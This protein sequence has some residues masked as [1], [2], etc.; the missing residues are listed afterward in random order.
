MVRVM[1]LPKNRE[2]GHWSKVPIGTLL[3]LLEG[4]VDELRKAITGRA[5]LAE[6]ESEAADVCNFAAMIRANYATITQEDRNAEQ[7]EERGAEA[8]S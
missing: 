3:S 4:E 5:P 8:G 6:V 2:K 1:A 7:L